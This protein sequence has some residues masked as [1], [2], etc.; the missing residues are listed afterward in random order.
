VTSWRDTNFVLA[1]FY[2]KP[3]SSL[4]RVMRSTDKGA[5]WSNFSGGTSAPLP[6]VGVSCVALDSV[7]P[8]RIWYAATD[9]GIYYTLDSGAHWSIAGAGI[10]LAPCTDVQI[11]ANKTTIRVATFGRGIW[12]ANTGT[13][14]VE[15]AGFTY[16][17]IQNANLIG[18]QLSWHTDSEHGSAFFVVERSIDGAAFEDLS[19]SIPSKAPGG[20]SS[21]MLDYAFFDSTHAAG[22][23]IYQ[24]K[25]IDLDGSVHFSNAVELHWGQSGLIVSQNYPNPFVIGTPS[26]TSGF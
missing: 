18:T 14:P 17:K 13:L 25:Q 5:H 12:E 7:D 4:A 23:Y 10:G 11:Q 2:T 19:P 26:S 24:L 20:T 3:G 21:T 15:L 6:L 22:D 8:L 9:N 1:S 16:Q